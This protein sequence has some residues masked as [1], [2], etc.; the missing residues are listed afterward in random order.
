[1]Q[2]TFMKLLQIDSSTTIHVRNLQYLMN[3]VKTSISPSVMNKV[4]E[5]MD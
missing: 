1:M 2:S 3:K 5:F 4:F